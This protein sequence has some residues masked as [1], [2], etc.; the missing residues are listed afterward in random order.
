MNEEILLSGIV[1]VIIG[2]LITSIGQIYINYINNKKY[3][4]RAEF[5]N[6]GKA[7]KLLSEQIKYMKEIQEW[8]IEFLNN[9][10]E[11]NEIIQPIDWAEHQRELLNTQNFINQDYS[12]DIF[13]T[14][15]Y[16]DNIRGFK[17]KK[18]SLDIYLNCIDTIINEKPRELSE[19]TDKDSIDYIRVRD[20]YYNIFSA[21][22]FYTQELKK[23]IKK[24]LQKISF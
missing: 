24:R 14:I 18:V 2:S 7:Y 8:Q 16:S 19:L 10:Q 17:N 11:N 6:L 15:N 22:E 9:K 1:G 5:E 21:F 4:N 23:A 12:S 13:I 3:K 20:E